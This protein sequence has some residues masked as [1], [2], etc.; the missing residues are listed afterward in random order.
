MVHLKVEPL[1][2]FAFASALLLRFTF[3]LFEALLHESHCTVGHDSTLTVD[4]TIDLLFVL[5]KL[6][7]LGLKGA[8][9]R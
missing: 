4:R 1:S 8:Y 9:V 6:E 3:Q 2:F 5:D 7:R